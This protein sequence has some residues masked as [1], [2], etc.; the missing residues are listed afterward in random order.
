MMELRQPGSAHDRFRDRPAAELVAAFR[1][2]RRLSPD[3]NEALLDELVRRNI[4]PED[5][6]EGRKG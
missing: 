6:P 2:W 1:D 5:W 3:D 4:R